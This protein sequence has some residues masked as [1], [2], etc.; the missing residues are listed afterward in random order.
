MFN[1]MVLMVVG[2]SQD[3]MTFS[4]KQEDGAPVGSANMSGILD[5]A[6]ASLSAAATSFAALSETDL[7]TTAIALR[8]RAR[9][10]RAIWDVLN[11][12]A[13]VGTA[14]AMAAA[15]TDAETVITRV[16]TSDW[17][18]NLVYS[19]ASSSNPM[20][21]NVNSRGENQWDES[22]VENT[23][24]GASGRTGNVTLLDP[25]TGAADAAV[26]TALTQWGDGIYAPVTM[27][28]ER[29]MRLIVAED[30]LAGG[31]TGEFETQI[32]AIRALDSYSGAF[33]QGGAV[34][35]VE[36]LTHTRRVNT[37]F[38]GLR[39]QDMYRWGI[40]MPGWDAQSAAITAPGTMLPITIIECRANQLIGEANC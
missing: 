21:S 15:R 14:L 28:S 36:A 12:T 4:D 26:G 29:L 40:T 16:G 3:D 34:S 6:I 25:V 2:E 20:V 38:M 7:E 31:D 24:P 17:K 39:L 22:L 8:A 1:G 13:T 5:D 23:G 33:V 27:T 30:A 11:P 35:D 10:S 19:A 18:Y 37:L 32:N 9:M